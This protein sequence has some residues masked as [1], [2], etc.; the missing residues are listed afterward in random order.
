VRPTYLAAVHAAL[1]DH[2]EAFAALER[3]VDERDIHATS[4]V[5][6]PFADSLR[7]D[8]RFPR[9]VRRL[10]LNP[11]PPAEC[12]CKDGDAR[13]NRLPTRTV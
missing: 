3:A 5:V 6:D 4:I 13:A 1:G 12:G 10:G 7:E 9:I 2:D 8:P 11:R